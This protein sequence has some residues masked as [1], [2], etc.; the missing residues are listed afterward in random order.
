MFKNLAGKFIS[1]EGTEGAGK[2]TLIAQIKTMLEAESLNVLT[3]REPGGTDVGEEI[4]EVLLA[5]RKV[6]LTSDTELLLFAAGRAQHIEEKIKPAILNN[7]CVLCDRFTDASSAYQGAGRGIDADRIAQLEAWVLQSFRPDVVVV[8][9][10]PVDVG[11]ARVRKR[12]ELDRIE[13]QEADFFERIRQYYLKKAKDEPSRYLV[14]NGEQHIN[15][16][17]NEFWDKI[18]AYIK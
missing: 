3:T 8:V 13:S 2:T 14:L 4:R 18:N 16:V 15:L 11:F 12:G 17:A 9:D 6:D 1:F 10:I 5:H 7:Y